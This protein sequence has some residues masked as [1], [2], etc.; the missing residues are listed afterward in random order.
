MVVEN[1]KIKAEMLEKMDIP[2][3][4]RKKKAATLPWAQNKYL[5]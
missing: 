2:P 1:D 4:T 5:Q 3:V